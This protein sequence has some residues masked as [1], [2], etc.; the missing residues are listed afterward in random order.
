[1]HALKH[2]AEK[3]HHHD[4]HAYDQS[5]TTATTTVIPDASLKKDVVVTETKTTAVAPVV[6]SNKATLDTKSN[7]IVTETCDYETIVADPI[8]DQKIRTD[9]LIEVQP[10]VH[11]EIDQEVVHHIEKHITE[12]PAASRAGEVTLAP[13]IIEHVHTRIIEE[14]QPIIHRE[15]A[16]QKV[17]KVQEYRTEHVVAPAQHLKEV[18][19]EK[20]TGKIDMHS[21]HQG[22]THI[23]KPIVDE[24]IRTD[25]LVEVQP[26]VH[27]EV[28]RTVVNH[29]EKHITEAPAPSM[30]GR[31]QLAPKVEEQ[32]H[33][34][35]VAEVQPIIHREK[36]VVKVDHVDQH[37]TE[38]VT[39]PAS[40]T[41][42]IVREKSEGKYIGVASTNADQIIKAPIIDEHIRTDVLLEVQ[43][44][45]HRDIDQDVVH[46]IERHIDE[47]P[48]PSLAG[49]VNLAPKIEEHVHTHVVNQVQPVVHRELAQQK[50]EIVEEHLTEKNCCTC[51]PH[52][53]GRHRE[54][55]RRI[56]S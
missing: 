39:A 54:C 56:R 25:V 35:E 55:S 53:R 26:I 8:V 48:A 33:V 34:R 50:V 43:P 52:S 42:D 36:A 38:H 13:K 19:H 20:S 28:D 21:H 2:L 24:K 31:V 5:E 1:M 30:A 9:V 32:I 45:V 49:V 6:V 10:V 46:H 40:H 15:V 7:V 11:K 18:T 12:A 27:R 37:V 41:H 17:E 44:V 29:V 47:K 3:L 23:S 51:Y 4:K 22:S 16:V 14:V